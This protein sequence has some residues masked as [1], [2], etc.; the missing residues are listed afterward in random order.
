MAARLAFLLACVTYVNAFVGPLA[1]ATLRSKHTNICAPKKT[2]VLAATK[3]CPSKLKMRMGQMEQSDDGI[4][5][6]QNGSDIRGYAVDSP[7]GK[8]VTLTNDRIRRIAFG[9]AS[10][11]REKHE[12]EHPIIHEHRYKVAIGRDSRI[13]GPRVRDALFEGL[14]SAG[15][16]VIDVGLATTPAMFKST[17]LPEFL[18]DAGIMITASHLPFDRNGLKFFTA[19]GGLSKKDITRILEVAKLPQYHMFKV[20]RGLGSVISRDLLSVYSAELVEMIR[21]G[22]Q[23]GD[24]PLEG[25]KILVDAGNGC[26]GYFV[27]QVLEPLGAI[28]SGSQFLEPDGMF[29]NHIPNPEDH[30]AM[31]MTR[32]AVL[33]HKADLGIIFDTDVDRAGAVDSS[34]EEINRNRLIALAAAITLE[35]HPGTTVVTDSVTSDG[36]TAFIESMGGKHHRFKRGYKNVIEEAIRLNGEGTPSFLAMETSGH[37]AQA[38]N[39]WLDDGAYTMVKLLIKMAKLKKE[40]KGLMSLIGTLK[41][42]RESVE[43]RLSLLK[44]DTFQQDGKNILESLAK[45]AKHQGGWT[46]VEP[47]YEGVRIQTGNSWFLLRMSLHD[48][49]MPLNIESTSKGGTLMTAIELEDFLEQFTAHGFG[50]KETATLDI[51]ALQQMT[52]LVHGEDLCEIPDTEAPDG[53]QCIINALQQENEELRKRVAELEGIMAHKSLKASNDLHM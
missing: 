22:A 10:F 13:S 45:Y 24:K 18:M 7:G 29:P 46:V 8:R 33:K 30:T 48:P 2:G 26:G 52:D 4:V 28:T 32:D 19:D 1:P 40:N 36:L 5:E 31:Q 25:L 11:I 38:D 20:G 35:E 47:N 50:S 23:M 27:D 49:V 41:E 9:F 12:R 51:S 21:N 6:L 42:P 3:F 39:S 44:Q 43:L 53:W 14:T 15:C 17:V 16:D 37:G 34:G